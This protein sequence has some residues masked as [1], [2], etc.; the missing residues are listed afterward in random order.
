MTPQEFNALV[1]A[2]FEKIKNTLI[3]KSEQYSRNN[4]RLHNFRRGAAFRKKTMSEVL[5]GM[6]LKHVIT[7]YDII[8]DI[9]SGKKVSASLFDEVVGD[10]INYAILLE[11][12]QN[13]RHLP[14]HQM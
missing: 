1:E 11:A 14:H 4:D 3:K 9:E 2:R 13:D 12:V 5:G 8:D 6:M 7:L 10:F